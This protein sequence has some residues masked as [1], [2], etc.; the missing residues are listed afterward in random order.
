MTE[1]CFTDSKALATFLAQVVR[2]GLTYKVRDGVDC[3]FVTLTGG[4]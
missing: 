4:F 3:W 1:I 2:E